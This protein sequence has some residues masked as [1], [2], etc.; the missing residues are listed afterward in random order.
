M[1]PPLPLQGMS[2]CGAAPQLRSRAGGMASLLMTAR[3]PVEG[4][5]CREGNPLH[6]P[7]A[8]PPPLEIEGR[9]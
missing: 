4:L 9:I 1:N 5:F 3:S 7:S 6:Q 8:G 2:R